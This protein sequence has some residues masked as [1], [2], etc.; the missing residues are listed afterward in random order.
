MLTEGELIA[1]LAVTHRLARA[2]NLMLVQTLSREY[3]A[4]LVA[5]DYR[6]INPQRFGEV[7]NRLRRLKSH[8]LILYGPLGLTDAELQA[9]I[10]KV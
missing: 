7:A 3:W 9:G 1:T 8:A 10:A 5:R 6:D 2:A 4:T